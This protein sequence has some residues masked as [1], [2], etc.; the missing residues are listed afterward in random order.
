MP[1]YSAR[2]R[3]HNS[4]SLSDSLASIQR[5]K[6]T[7]NFVDNRPLV[8]I[9]RK[10]QKLA[11]DN[12]TPLGNAATASTNADEAPIQ[13][14]DYMRALN[15]DGRVANEITSL[16]REFLNET[17]REH[18]VNTWVDGFAGMPTARRNGDGKHYY[19]PVGYCLE[20]TDDADVLA[21]YSGDGNTND[22]PVTVP[23]WVTAA[24]ALRTAVMQVQ[25]YVTWSADLDD[26]PWGPLPVADAETNTAT[27]NI[28][29][30]YYLKPYLDAP[31]VTDGGDAI[32]GRAAGQVAVRNAI[33]T[34]G[35]ASLRA[36]YDTNPGGGV[37]ERFMGPGVDPEG[38]E[39]ALADG[40]ARYIETILHAKFDQVKSAWYNRDLGNYSETAAQE[41][42][43]DAEGD[44]LGNRR[45][46]ANAIRSSFNALGA[47]IN[48]EEIGPA[49]EMPEPELEM[50]SPMG[51]G[52]AR[53]EELNP[54]Y[55]FAF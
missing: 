36:H 11:E 9:Q 55:G 40:D 54:D 34:A 35:L 16:R 1:A 3:A 10:L 26:D 37:G 25:D 20:T 19:S 50:A 33:K 51:T 43:R 13:R 2:P 52:G 8:S 18:Q 48:V 53:S 45:V 44:W 7:Q 31:T 14:A 32:G 6:S 49:P 23:G 4:R 15:G 21:N 30:N 12:A 5:S 38:M 24:Q 29:I 41:N 42:W 39:D 28:Y 27:R 47:N 22:V 46:A 17:N